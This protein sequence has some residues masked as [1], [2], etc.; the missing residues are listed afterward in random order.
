VKLCSA[1]LPAC[2]ALN[3]DTAPSLQQASLIFLQAPKRDPGSS[4]DVILFGY[5]QVAPRAAFPND[6]HVH[7]RGFTTH[8][9]L[10]NIVAAF[11]LLDTNS[12]DIP[13]LS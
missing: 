13:T 11:L 1:A 6:L 3:G 9:T 7:A 12:L 4:A 5:C 10:T 8:N 2:H